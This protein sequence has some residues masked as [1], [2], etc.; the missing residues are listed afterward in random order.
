MGVEDSDKKNP[1]S[2]GDEF[3]KIL[4]PEEV[5]KIRAKVGNRK[6]AERR[7]A[8]LT[9][10]ALFDDAMVSDFRED[11]IKAGSS[12][13]QTYAMDSL[14]RI[15]QPEDDIVG[16]DL[17]SCAPATITGKVVENDTDD[18]RTGALKIMKQ[19]PDIDFKFDE[20]RQR[21]M[22]TYTATLKQKENSE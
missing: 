19:Y 21:G 22:F 16:P 12:Y 5:E 1:W 17:L 10:L 13:S 11:L 8:P 4:G 7:N 6:E 2:R 14:G 20:D 3:E 18:L 15:T 9:G